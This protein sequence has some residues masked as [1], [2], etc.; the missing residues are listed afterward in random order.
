MLNAVLFSHPTGLSSL[1]LTSAAGHPLSLDNTHHSNSSSRNLT[2]DFYTKFVVKNCL[3]AP[4]GT[5]A[6]WFLTILA[7]ETI[8]CHSLTSTPL[9]KTVVARGGDCA[10]SK[11]SA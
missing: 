11:S 4:I 7:A 5:K 9:I 2:S 6:A 3:C 8:C 10:P 1:C